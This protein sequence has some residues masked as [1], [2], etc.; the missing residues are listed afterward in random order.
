[1]LGRSS[2]QH[3]ARTSVYAQYTSAVLTLTVTSIR[4]N[5]I[6][7]T[8]RS[9]TEYTVCSCSRCPH[10]REPNKAVQYSNKRNCSHFTYSTYMYYSPGEALQ[11]TGHSDRHRAHP[12][13]QSEIRRLRVGRESGKKYLRVRTSQKMVSPLR[14]CVLASMVLDYCRGSQQVLEIC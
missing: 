9:E 5:P 2:V 11:R 12:N 7:D 1:V 14:S 13:T 8:D 4:I 10:P 3:A 6:R